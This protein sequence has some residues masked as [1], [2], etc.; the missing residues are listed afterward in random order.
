MF[1][2]DHQDAGREE[3]LRLSELIGW[4]LDWSLN[5]LHAVIFAVVWESYLL[6][7]WY[8]SFCYLVKWQTLIGVE[9][10]ETG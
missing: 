9:T 5:E 1:D 3:Y 7:V 10:R 6:V 8:F 2:Q 4:G